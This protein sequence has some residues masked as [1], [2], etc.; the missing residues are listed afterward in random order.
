MM[1][2]RSASTSKF[3]DAGWRR[4]VQLRLKVGWDL[5]AADCIVLNSY[6]ITIEHK[7]CFGVGKAN[8]LCV[9]LH[10]SLSTKALEIEANCSNKLTFDNTA[11]LSLYCLYQF[12]DARIH[13][14]FC[15]SLCILC[16]RCGDG[17]QVALSIQCIQNNGIQFASICNGQDWSRT[18]RKQDMW[19]CECGIDLQSARSASWI[20]YRFI[21]SSQAWIPLW[22]LHVLPIEFKCKRS[23]TKCERPAFE[24]SSAP[25]AWMVA[26]LELVPGLERTKKSGLQVS[27]IQV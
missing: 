22:S 13:L 16:L 19:W 26:P 20:S 23:N 9:A 18:D 1:V 10:S 8:A 6:M 15:G 2:S 5:N 4:Q 11:A 27:S 7:T 12:W 17:L 14:G 24:E 25:L 3:Q 21:S